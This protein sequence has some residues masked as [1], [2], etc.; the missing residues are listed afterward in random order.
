MT[1]SFVCLE[2]R[3]L[4]EAAHIVKLRNYPPEPEAIAQDAGHRGA[5]PAE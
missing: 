1:D 2:K 3:A 5:K 4:T